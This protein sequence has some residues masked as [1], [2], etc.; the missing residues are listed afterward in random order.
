MDNLIFLILFFLSVINI[1]IKGINDFFFDYM[2]L[3][4]T[5]SIKGIFVWMIILSHYTGYYKENE[6]YIFKKILNSFGQKMV[7]L[8]L[9]YSGFG[10]YE[11]IKKKG[12]NY[13][14]KLP[15]KCIILLIKSQIILLFYLINNLI[16]GIKIKLTDYFGSIIFKSSIGNSNWFAFTIISLYFYS[17][18]SFKFVNCKLNYIS[19]VILSF[20]CFLHIYLVYNYFYPKM[21]FAVDNILCFIF[22][23][24]H[25]LLI[26]KFNKIIMKNDIIYFGILSIL[27]SIYYY[28]YI[29][30]NK[31]ILIVSITNSFFC[32]I[33]VFISLKI[34][35]ENEFLRLLN[36]HSFSIYLL[37]RL[38]MRFI[39]FKKYFRYSNILRFFV[40]FILIL[41][42]SII[43]DTYTTFIDKIFNKKNIEKPK[44]NFNI[45][46]EKK[47]INLK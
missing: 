4:N 38:V 16:L 41:L 29:Y 10:I 15:I 28:Y 24:Y 46:E 25:S 32:L 47:I 20:I 43:F 34:R 5:N 23:F 30:T 44:V 27:V 40:E 11:S 17:F 42:I 31:T 35:F 3:K 14:N 45:E 33:V 1:S 36:T 2:N 19:I 21:R 39:Y 8:F 9:F 18:I 37:Q 22:G 6:K 26:N 12:L 7:S 13:V